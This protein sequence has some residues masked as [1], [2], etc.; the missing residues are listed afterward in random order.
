MLAV[1]APFATNRN[2]LK[3]AL[4]KA[5]SLVNFQTPQNLILSYNDTSYVDA[6]TGNL[7]IGLT[8]GSTTHTFSRN[9]K[10]AVSQQLP[11]IA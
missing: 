9:A 4:F 2:T 7:K 3:L 5:A 10:I 8:L 11:V 1:D 6:L